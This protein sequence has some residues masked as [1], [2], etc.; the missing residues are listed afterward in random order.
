LISINIISI[1]D[2]FQVDPRPL[3]EA[4]RAK[5]C[6]EAETLGFM[7]PII[8]KLIQVDM[9]L[10]VG[11]IKVMPVFGRLATAD[12]VNILCCAKCFY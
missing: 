8:A 2:K 10:C 3:S 11:I 4:I 1:I 12:K 5:L 6:A 9:L 7:H